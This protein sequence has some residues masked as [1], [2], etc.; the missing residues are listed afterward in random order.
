LRAS[1]FPELFQAKV[2]PKK[3]KT[4]AVP[5]VAV[6]EPTIQEH[7]NQVTADTNQAD[8]SLNENV[9]YFAMGEEQVGPVSLADARV[10]LVSGNLEI[11][12]F[13]WKEGFPEWIPVST[14]PEIMQTETQQINIVTSANNVQ[15]AGEICSS[16]NTS[17]ICGILSL[18]VL[19]F[20]GSF[21]AIIFGNRALTEIKLSENRLQGRN[22]AVAGIVMG[23]ISIG[24]TVLGLVIGLIIAIVTHFV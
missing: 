2:Q 9:W 17:M 20:V 1:Q 12:D 5:E 19:F 8:A 6:Q 7:E 18:S 15:H 13:A 10:M 16:A 14:V 4:P 23:Y 21:P 24:L 3:R 11:D 22:Y